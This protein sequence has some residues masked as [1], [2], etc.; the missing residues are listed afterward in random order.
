MSRTETQRASPLLEQLDKVCPERPLGGH[1]APAAACGVRDCAGMVRVARAAPCEPAGIA[2]LPRTVR[3]L[4]RHAFLFSASQQASANMH[5]REIWPAYQILWSA[6]AIGFSVGSRTCPVLLLLRL[7]PAGWLLCRLRGP[8]GGR[9]WHYSS[10]AA[11]VRSWPSTLSSH[12]KCPAIDVA[13]TIKNVYSRMFIIADELEAR[14]SAHIR[15]VAIV[16]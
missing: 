2:D 6:H 5:T 10:S 7:W 16:A 4:A 14:K 1:A 15:Q 9:L 3:L 8:L 11:E 13:I 12:A